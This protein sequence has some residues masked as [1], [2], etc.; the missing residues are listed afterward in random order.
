MSTECLK[1]VCIEC[2]LEEVQL[3]NDYTKFAVLNVD[4]WTASQGQVKQVETAVLYNE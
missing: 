4:P 3:G 1:T 2:I